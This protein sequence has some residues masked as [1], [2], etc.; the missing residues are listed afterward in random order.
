[1]EVCSI[2]PI[3]RVRSTVKGLKAK[4]HE[5]GVFG[6]DSHLNRQKETGLATCWH[7]ITI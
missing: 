7:L 1:M 4:V 2:K 6:I 5:K 3:W